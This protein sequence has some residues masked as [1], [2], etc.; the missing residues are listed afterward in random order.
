MPVVTSKVLL[1]QRKKKN[2]FSDDAKHTTVAFAATSLGT[3]VYKEIG[4]SQPWASL[5][6]G[7]TTF[8]AGYAKEHLIDEFADPGDINA[9]TNGLL[10]GMGLTI[11]F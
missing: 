9:N 3:L 2:R 10:M 6:A 4:V 11:W 5:L 7:T 8:M 1:N